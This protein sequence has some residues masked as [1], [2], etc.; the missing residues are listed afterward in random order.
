MNINH[1]HKTLLEEDL[2]DD[3]LLRHL[4]GADEDVVEIEYQKVI[5]IIIKLFDVRSEDS[6]YQKIFDRAFDFEKLSSEMEMTVDVFLEKYLNTSTEFSRNP[7][8]IKEIH[9]ICEELESSPRVFV[10]ATSTPEM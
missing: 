5:D 7:E 9:Q 1:E 3:T 4:V 10:I 6:K 2:G 8:F